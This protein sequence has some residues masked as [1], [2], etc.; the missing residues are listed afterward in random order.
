MI[1]KEKVYKCYYCNKEIDPEELVEKRIPLKTKKGMRM[2]R[3]KLH[4]DC[5]PELVKNMTFEREYLVEETDWRKCYEKFRELLGYS[6]NDSLPN[7][8]VMRIKGMR[9]GKFTPNGTNTTSLKG[10]HSYDVILKTL[11]FCASDIRYAVATVNFKNEQHKIN[12]CL[13]IVADKLDWMENKMESKKRTDEVMKSMEKEDWNN[14]IGADYIPKGKIDTTVENL[15][16]E[17]KEQE[18][19]NNIDFDSLFN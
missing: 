6:S 8:A 16:R 12:Y 2:Y 10:G 5:V 1:G 14:V 4:I 9:V 13:R 19:A 3:R 7:F 18:D 17:E 15:I 11:M